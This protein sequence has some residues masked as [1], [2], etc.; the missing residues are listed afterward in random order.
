MAGL[1][2]TRCA[3]E[4]L[5]RYLYYGLVCYWWRMYRLSAQ[6]PHAAFPRGIYDAGQLHS[7][8]I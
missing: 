4:Q 2:Q 7:A 6:N 3:P 1:E 8:S 5:P